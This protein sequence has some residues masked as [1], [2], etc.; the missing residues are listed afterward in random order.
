MTRSGD[1]KNASL[2]DLDD[3]LWSLLLDRE[4]VLHARE[5]NTLL[6][7]RDRV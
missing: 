2:P 4:Y 7:V 3:N 1:D 5:K 6:G